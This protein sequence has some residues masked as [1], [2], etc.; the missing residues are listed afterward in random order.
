MTRLLILV[1]LIMGVINLESFTVD[2]GG[3]AFGLPLGMLSLGAAWFLHRSG[4]WAQKAKRYVAEN[5][6]PPAEGVRPRAG[7]QHRH[8]G[9]RVAIRF[10]PTDT[11]DTFLAVTLDGEPVSP[12]DGRVTVDAMAP[13]QVVEFRG[14]V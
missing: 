6:T 4:R 7:W 10:L 1:N 11:P 13:G 14:P 8:D 5:P 12:F 9:R 3:H 2:P